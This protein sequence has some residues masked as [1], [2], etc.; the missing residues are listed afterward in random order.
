MTMAAD[1]HDQQDRGDR[2]GEED[3][4]IAARDDQRAPQVVLQQRPE[5]E[6][7]QQRRRLAAELDQRVAE[8][9]EERDREHVP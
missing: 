2:P 4:Q 5:H 9:A 8:E 7:E 3:R 1:R 6:A